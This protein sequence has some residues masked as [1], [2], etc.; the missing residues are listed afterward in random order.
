[1]ASDG[2]SFQINLGV[3]GGSA[4]V[5]AANAAARLA[6][7]LVAAG[8]AATAAADAVKASEASYKQAESA[9]DRAAKAL[10]RIGLAADA[11]RGKVKEALDA[12][13]ADGAAKASAKLAQ[14]IARQ[15]EAAAKATETAAAVLAEAAA[16]DKLKNAATEASEAEEKISSAHDQAK[17]AAEATEKATAA[18]KGSGDV[19]DLADAFEKLGGPLGAIGGK[20]GD[21]TD[22]F[23]KLTGSLGTAGGVY[24]GIALA[25]TAVTVALVAG[26]AALMKFA[27]GSADASRSSGLLA[28]G[29]AQ[30]VA[31]GEALEAK[32]HA[33]GT[34]VPQTRDELMSMAGELAKTGLRGKELTDALEDAAVKAATLKYGPDFQR[35][36]I[37]LNSLTTRLHD[38]IKDLFKGVMIERFLQSLSSIVELFDSTTVSGNAMKVALTTLVQPVIDGLANLGPVIVKTFIQFEIWVMRALIAIKP[39]GSTIVTV[40]KIV[41]V[42]VLAIGA[43]LAVA[44]GVIVGMAAAAGALVIGLGYLGAKFTELLFGAQGLG[45]AIL[46]G[47]GAAFDWLMAKA[48][49]VID[50][51]AGL[52]LVTIGTQLITGLAQGILSGGSAVTT[53]ITGIADGAINAAKSIF[54]IQSPSAVFAEIGMQTGAGMQKG[55]DGSA[56]GVQGSI[57]AML[58]V[59]SGGA[60]TTDASVTHGGDTYNIVVQGGGGGVEEIV[61]AVKRGILEAKMRTTLSQVPG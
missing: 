9:A 8:N 19:G 36:T 21:A 39:F 29:I 20:A 5:D 1:M 22:A 33:L 35:Q 41:G 28:A 15:D 32:I 2:T 51:I 54:K 56:G 30:S 48:Q 18:A 7:E 42:A 13:D 6:D 24:L 14:L 55:I 59:P 38:N 53:A 45:A 44:A 60:G 50:F 61:D 34:Q 31:G 40:A 37:S 49:A 11:Q 26:A 23:K 3:A 12:G 43:V 46:S 10:E 16:L 47:P 25:V 58:A 57:D 4:A 17:K 27:I 52:D